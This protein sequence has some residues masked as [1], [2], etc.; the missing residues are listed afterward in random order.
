MQQ[1]KGSC[2]TFPQLEP[3]VYVYMPCSTA[4]DLCRVMRKSPRITVSADVMWIAQGG[5]WVSP[6]LGSGTGANLRC[7][8]IVQQTAHITE[9]SVL[10]LSA[11]QDVP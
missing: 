10:F 11:N 6:A 4:T 2:K 3:V 7:S 9:G 1:G 8:N 5:N